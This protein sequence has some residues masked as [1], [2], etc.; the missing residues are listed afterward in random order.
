MRHRCF[1]RGARF[2]AG[3]VLNGAYLPGE[4][5]EIVDDYVELKDTNSE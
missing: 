1:G 5:L 2:I 4:T 3:D